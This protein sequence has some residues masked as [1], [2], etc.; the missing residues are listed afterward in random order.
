MP[1]SIISAV[2]IMLPCSLNIYVVE[3]NVYFFILFPGKCLLAVFRGR[4]LQ[5]SNNDQL[6]Q[7]D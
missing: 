3:T 2:I 7:L 6:V 1:R 5:V 4:R